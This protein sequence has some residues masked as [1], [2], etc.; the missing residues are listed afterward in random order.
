MGGNVHAHLDGLLRSSTP[1]R[2]QP[3][4]SRVRDGDVCW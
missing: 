4:P 3:V 1:M 2:S